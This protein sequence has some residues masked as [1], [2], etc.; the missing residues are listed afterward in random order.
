MLKLKASEFFADTHA[1]SFVGV[2]SEVE[3]TSL[4]RDLMVSL[5]S[6]EA[7][8]QFVL[9]AENDQDLIH[10]SYL[11]EGGAEVGWSGQS[12]QLGA[13]NLLASYAPQARFQ[14]Q[15]SPR[16]QNIELMVRPQLLA[17]L[18]GEEYDALALHIREGFC[19]RVGPGCPEADRSAR[20]LARVLRQPDISPL[21][22]QAA[23]LEFLGW[24]LQSFNQARD[25]GLPRQERQQL[26]RARAMLLQDLTTPPTIAALAREVGIGQLRLKRGFRLLYGDSIY[27]CFLRHRMERARQLLERHS[28]TETAVAVGYSNISHFSACFRKHFGC[29]PRDIRAR[30]RMA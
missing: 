10:F 6:F 24:Q 27:A 25:S 2:R 16:Y 7:P 23:A 17:E 21:L 1:A 22:R 3:S 4:M 29:L 8:E 14:L 20:S 12:H 5:V 18:A 13:G 30:S 26:A 9:A 19:F 15:L 28:V 11:F